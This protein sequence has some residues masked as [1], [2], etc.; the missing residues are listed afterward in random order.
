MEKKEIIVFALGDIN[1][2]RTWSNIP[3]FLANTLE[4]KGHIVHRVNLNGW[5]QI[6]E[7]ISDKLLRMFK[8]KST[9]SFQRTIFYRWI[10]NKRM[11]K[12]I[13][14]YKD[15]DYVFLTA[16]SYSAK[17]V[18]VKPT[19]LF[20]DWTYEYLIEEM[21]RREPTRLEARE[22]KRQNQQIESADHVVT[23]F[24]KIHK[25][26][27]GK[28][29]NKNIHYLGNVI[30][31]DMTEVSQD[32]IDEKF[33]SNKIVFIG[34]KKYLDGANSL[35]QG[36]QLYN[37]RNPNNK[38]EVQIIGMSND[39]FGIEKPD[40]VKC[41]GYLY[42]HKKEQKELYY[43][44]LKTAKVCINT[45]KNWAGFSSM[46]ECMYYM[47]P[48]ITTPYSEFVETFGEKIEFGYYCENNTSELICRYLCRL[49]NLK[50]EAYKN[51]C[52]RAHQSVAR[53]TWDEYVDRML[54]LFDDSKR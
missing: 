13:K 46:I 14:E 43:Q 6:L 26:M 45:N 11:K 31:T 15:V 7:R 50:G 28:Y 19:L 23:L 27:M 22:I 35:I 49:N 32:M 39:V 17:E 29:N 48:V 38:Y 34:I 4:K 37:K 42:K 25:Y 40:F 51:M 20:H 52:L 30:N 18:S 3:Y 10:A 53:F 5:E 2:P 47:T 33:T 44:I 54:E 12:A 24:P 1:S 21:K 16:F 9:F 8:V 36:V 41:H